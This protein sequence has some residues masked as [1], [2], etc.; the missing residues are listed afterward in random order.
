MIR[1][2]DRSERFSSRPPALPE[3]ASYS[4][5]DRNNFTID[6]GGTICDTDRHEVTRIVSGAS[7]LTR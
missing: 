3:V 2:D 1:A 6:K 4:P 5:P 7:R